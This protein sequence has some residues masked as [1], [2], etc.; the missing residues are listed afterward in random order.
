MFVF[1]Y[2]PP[3]SKCWAKIAEIANTNQLRTNNTLLG[4]N[5]LCTKYQ[6]NLIIVQGLER[7]LD[8]ITR[9]A[10]TYR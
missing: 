4:T 9:K 5:K 10:M 7:E 6:F 1:Q 3:S 8:D 2:P